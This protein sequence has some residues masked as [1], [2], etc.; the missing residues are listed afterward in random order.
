MGGVKL[1]ILKVYYNYIYNFN[2]N[3]ISYVSLVT[4]LVY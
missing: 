3:Y 2:E 4:L 1:N